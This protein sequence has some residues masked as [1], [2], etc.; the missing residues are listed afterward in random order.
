M[1]LHGNEL[2][3]RLTR[4]LEGRPEVLEAYLFGSEAAGRAQPHSDVDVAVF[5]AEV[6]DA[7]F[8][9]EAELSADLIAALGENRVD[10]VLLNRA[11]PLLYHHVLS[12]GVRLL[13]RD[14]AATTVREGLAISRY[15][16]YVP[17]LAKLD[18]ALRARIVRGN[19]GR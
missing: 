15:C 13:S 16:D 10:L 12:E 1:P 4:A 11:P 3:D 9:Y 6:P 19:F 18:A 5:V 17:H 14:P 7:P 2:R 8:G